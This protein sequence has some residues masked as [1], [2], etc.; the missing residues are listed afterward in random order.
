MITEITQIKPLEHRII[1][2]DFADFQ[3]H[4]YRI[5]ALVS[6]NNYTS[7]DALYRDFSF[8]VSFSAQT[9]LAF[10]QYIIIKF[11]KRIVMRSGVKCN[12]LLWLDVKNFRTKTQS[13]NEKSHKKN[14]SEGI[15]EKR[16]K[17]N[18]TLVT[19]RVK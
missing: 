6:R 5:K 4:F 3:S 8:G 17:K 13:R 9:K 7:F 12:T 15:N 1:L 18:A 11:D 2:T 10:Q 16:P 19:A 14:V